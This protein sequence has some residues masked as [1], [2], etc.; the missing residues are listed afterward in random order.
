M[1]FMANFGISPSSLSFLSVK[2]FNEP[3]RLKLANKS[4]L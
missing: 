2:I 3:A 1:S 4:I